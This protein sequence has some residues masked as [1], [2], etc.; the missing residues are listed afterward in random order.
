MMATHGSNPDVDGKYQPSGYTIT[1]SSARDT[2]ATTKDGTGA[3]SYRSFDRLPDNNV[4][5]FSQPRFYQDV[6][7]IGS[8]ISNTNNAYDMSPIGR[9]GEDVACPYHGPALQGHPGSP[10]PDRVSD[11]MGRYLTEGPSQQYAIFQRPDTGRLSTYRECRCLE[12][13]EHN[14][15]SRVE[16][17]QDYLASRGETSNY[18]YQASEHYASAVTQNRRS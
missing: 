12:A 11:L 17:D 8:H 10:L 13:I 6:S 7:Y 1:T 18:G 15:A 9:M 2:A 4:P 3:A 16:F 14:P 5:P